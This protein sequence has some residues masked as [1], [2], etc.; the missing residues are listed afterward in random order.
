MIVRNSSEQRLD[1]VV[2]IKINAYFEFN[3]E[4]GGNKESTET[5][6]IRLLSVK[7]LLW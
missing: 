1:I 6:K 5:M 2:K 7:M 3:S 4:G